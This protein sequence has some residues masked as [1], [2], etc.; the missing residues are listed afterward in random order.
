MV[1]KNINRRI[2]ILAREDYIEEVPYTTRTKHGRVDYRLTMMGFRSLI[3]HFLNHTNEIQGLVKYI[4]K[5]GL[6]KIRVAAILIDEHVKSIEALNEFQK[7]SGGML[8][9]PFRNIN[10]EELESILDLREIIQ[11]QEIYDDML[12]KMQSEIQISLKHIQD[13]RVRIRDATGELKSKD[14]KI[15]KKLAEKELVKRKGKPTELIKAISESNQTMENT[16]SKIA[17]ISNDIKERE[18]IK[19]TA[20]IL[21][22][23][24]AAQKAVGASSPLAGNISQVRN[25]MGGLQTQ[26]N[27]TAATLPKLANG[28]QQVAAESFKQTVEDMKEAA[29]QTAEAIKRARGRV[30]TSKKKKPA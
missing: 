30:R 21:E 6:D 8:Y 17:K 19:G 18:M 20:K 14:V 9:D 3:P 15:S 2:L 5:F 28:Q 4:D 26:I 13:S 29:P 1:Y 10:Y 24:S 12:K 27:S 11:L 16:E 22:E 23:T 25:P 7:Q